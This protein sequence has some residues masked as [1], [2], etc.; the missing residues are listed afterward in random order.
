MLRVSAK[1][2]APVIRSIF[3]GDSRLLD[4]TLNTRVSKMLDWSTYETI[5]SLLGQVLRFDLSP[6]AHRG[7]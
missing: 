6:L 7:G 5:R 4:L 2:H 3:T 1:D